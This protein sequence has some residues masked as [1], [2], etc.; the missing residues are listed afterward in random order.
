MLLWKSGKQSVVTASTSESELVEILEGALAG[1]AIRVV[2]EEALDVKARAVSFT[3]STVAISIIT[4]DS[5]SW[6]TRHLRKRA[7]ILRSKV[8]LGEWLLRHMPGSKLPADLG[9]KVLSSEKFKNLKRVMG[10]FLAEE[11]KG[12]EEKSFE[13]EEKKEVRG[14]QVEVVK[15]ALKALILFAKLAKARGANEDAVQLWTESLPISSFT[16]PASGLP[17]FVIILMIFFFGMITGAVLAWM[18]NYPYFHRVTL[19]E[20]RHGFVPRPSFFTHPLPEHRENA[21]RSQR[22]TAPLPRRSQLTST[23]SVLSAD[24]TD[25]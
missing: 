24:A 16:E 10:M 5:G 12:E 20:S 2:L 13:K 9:T 1:D 3:D 4:A 22:S 21:E 14:N 11:E 25:G 18:A 7:H 17:Y 19:V 15:T 6:R 8:A 23:T